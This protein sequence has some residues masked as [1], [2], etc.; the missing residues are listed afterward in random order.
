MPVFRLTGTARRAAAFLF[1]ALVIF[2]CAVPALSP[3]GLG[4]IGQRFGLFRCVAE[5]SIGM[6][7]FRLDQGRGRSRAETGLALG[8]AVAG[9]MAFLLA[10]AADYMLVPMIFAA[11]IYGLSDERGPLARLLRHPALQWLGVVSYSTYLS[12]YFLK[13]WTKFILVRPGMSADL[14]FPAYVAAV[15]IASALLYR[16][17]ER[18]GQRW[19][20]A[21]L[22]T[23]RQRLPA[24]EGLP[25]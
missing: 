22:L 14:P 12:H 8:L 9:A 20:R 10:Q 16:Y 2:A 4:F 21:Q 15:L 17:V 25:R 18:P 24:R 6:G 1:A 11:L 5:F 3:S 7:I 19:L 23:T 13:I